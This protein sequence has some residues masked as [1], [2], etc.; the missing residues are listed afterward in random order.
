MFVHTERPPFNQTWLTGKMTRRE[1]EHYHAEDLRRLEEK[2]RE[3][4]DSAPARDP[5]RKDG[6]EAPPEL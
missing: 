5:Q 2:E 1:M 3:E 6:D 4:V